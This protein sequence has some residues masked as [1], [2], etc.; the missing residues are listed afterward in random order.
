MYFGKVVPKVGGW[1]SDP[2]AYRYLPRS[3]AYLPAPDELIASLRASGFGDASRRA[4]H[5]RRVPAVH[6]DA[7][8]LMRAVSEPADEATR[9]LDLNDVARGD[10]YLFV[11][12]GVGLAGRGVAA[13]IPFDEAPAA[14][15]AI[16]HDDRTPLGVAPVGIGWIPFVP[17]EPGEVVIPRVAVVKSAAGDC[18]VTRVDGD[19]GRRS[20]AD[21]GAA[22]VR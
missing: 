13:R 1:L 16:E 21:D 12:D 6:G 9:G 15:A 22:A 8:S 3:V 19:D 7:R 20:R 17:G 2:A 10:G 18:W 11:R 4:A 14:L 5:A